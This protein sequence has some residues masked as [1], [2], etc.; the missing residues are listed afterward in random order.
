MI[1]AVWGNAA[2]YL[3]SMFSPNRGLTADANVLG[4]ASLFGYLAYF[5]AIGG[6]IGLMLATLMLFF[7]PQKTA[8]TDPG[9]GN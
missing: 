6:A 1:V 4:P 2:F 8:G 7:A 3:F 5:P 9:V